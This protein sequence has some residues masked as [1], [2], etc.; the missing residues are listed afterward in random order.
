MRLWKARHASFRRKSGVR[1][2]DGPRTRLEVEALDQRLVPSSVPNLVGL[3][4]DFHGYLP[5]GLTIQSERDQGGG[6]ETFVGVYTDKMDGVST[7]VSGTI[8]LKGMVPDPGP[9][10]G[11][12]EY[13]FGVKFSGARLSNVQFNPRTGIWSD[14]VSRVSASGDFYTP[15]ISG[16]LGA[17]HGGGIPWLYMGQESDSLTYNSSY[18]SY[19][20]A[21]YSNPHVWTMN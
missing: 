15:T 13:D 2:A 12:V 20:L 19:I 4:L 9:L 14:E 5:N 1:R 8:T 7:S 18:R 10:P 16:N 17:Y 11:S 6:K 3:Y 21:S